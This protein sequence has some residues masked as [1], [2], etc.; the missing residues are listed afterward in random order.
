MHAAG[1]LM[2]WMEAA[3]GFILALSAVVTAEAL[4]RYTEA[5]AARRQGI[6]ARSDVNDARA[7]AHS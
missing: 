5:D 7:F 6:L 1:E 3:F 2:S 4:A